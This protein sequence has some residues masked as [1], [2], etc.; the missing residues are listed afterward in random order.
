MAHPRVS[1]RRSSSPVP[2]VAAEADL[3][4]HPGGRQIEEAR[5]LGR[6]RGLLKRGCTSPARFS[7]AVRLGTGAPAT[8][9][10]ERARL[11]RR[12]KC[13]VRC[14]LLTEGVHL[15]V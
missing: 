14:L 12:D 2:R 13:V 1:T 15:G 6:G 11:L 9:L 8:L 7:A 5:K 3:A 10:V 4:G